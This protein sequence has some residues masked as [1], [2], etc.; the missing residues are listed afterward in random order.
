MGPILTTNEVRSRLR[1]SIRHAHD[2]FDRGEI[3][4]FR[5]GRRKLYYERSLM[6]YIAR[7]RNTAAPAQVPPAPASPVKQR[8]PAR[9]LP[10]M[11]SVALDFLSRVKGGAGRSGDG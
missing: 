11:G 5:D 6:A 1:C 8:G 2:L 10:P 7:N 4:G 9:P 3:E